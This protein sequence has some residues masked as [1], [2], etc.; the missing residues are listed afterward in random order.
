MSLWTPLIWLALILPLL[1]IAQL[2]SKNTNPKYLLLFGG[3][4]LLDSY[5]RILGFELIE[6]D[7]LHLNWS[8]T[9]LSLILALVF[10]VSHSKQIREDIGFTTNFS[11]K[12]LK[13]GIWIFLGFLLFDFIFK[14]IL[15]PKGGDFDSEQLLFQATMPGL[16]EEIVYRGILLWVLSKAFVPSKRIK[17]VSFGWGFVIVTFLF[18]MIH[19]VVLTEALE[20]KVDVITII[21]LTLITSLSVGILRKFSGN[22][23]LP[24]VRLRKNLPFLNNFVDYP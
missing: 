9:F 18:A 20:F 19:G 4:F 6:F 17:G 7:F 5:V 14:I 1:T 12:T 16:S 8:G 15:F 10:I 11:K 24:T 13:L 23:I 21:Y 2:T 3:Y 22:L